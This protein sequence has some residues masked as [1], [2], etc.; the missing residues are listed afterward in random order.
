MNA[1]PASTPIFF[2]K[3]PCTEDTSPNAVYLRPMGVLPNGNAAH[4]I[5]KGQE[6][7]IVGSSDFLLPGQAMAITA[8]EFQAEIDKVKKPGMQVVEIAKAMGC[9][10]GTLKQRM[11][12]IRNHLVKR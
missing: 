6:K 5:Q 3:L 2:K 10:V 4:E 12:L 8:Q 11:K 9:S 7:W 1:I